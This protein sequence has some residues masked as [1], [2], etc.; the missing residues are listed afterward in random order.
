MRAASLLRSLES[1]VSRRGQAGQQV[2][3][4][5]EILDRALR[6]KER[7]AAL[8]SMLHHYLPE[9]AD[10]E[11]PAGAPPPSSD[12]TP[13]HP[14]APE[15]DTTPAPEARSVRRSAPATAASGGTPLAARR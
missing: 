5:Q 4:P 2:A 6:G 1:L 15:E 13:E 7:E 8:Q 9:A 10:Q 12:P 3:T 11:G 14:P